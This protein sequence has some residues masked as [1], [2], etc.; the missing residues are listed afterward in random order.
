MLRPVERVVRRL[1]EQGLSE[2]EI[3][4]RLRRSPGHVQRLLAL[5]ELR[6]VAGPSVAPR[7]GSLRPIERRVL[8]SREAGIE[9]VEIAARLRRSPEFV[10][11]VATYAGYKIQRQGTQ[12]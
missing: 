12:R 9:P 5:T 8:R 6:R 7:S 1:G 3:A 10:K 11:R 4:W 2:S